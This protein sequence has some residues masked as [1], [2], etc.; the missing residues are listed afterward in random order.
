MT[1]ASESDVLLRP[2]DYPTATTIAPSS[3]TLSPKVT[4]GKDGRQQ[5]IYEF[6]DVSIM[7]DPYAYKPGSYDADADVQRH[8]VYT[9]RWSLF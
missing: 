6:S 5:H 1:S 4:L 7:L 8:A 9:A 3:M 2:P